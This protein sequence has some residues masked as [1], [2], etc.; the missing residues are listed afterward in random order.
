MIRQVD[1]A[2]AEGKRTLE[3]D[4]LSTRYGYYSGNGFYYARQLD[5]PIQARATARPN[6]KWS[7]R[8]YNF[9][10]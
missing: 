9:A 5:E 4:P 1:E 2:V 10:P 3:L 6:D 8:S 7:K